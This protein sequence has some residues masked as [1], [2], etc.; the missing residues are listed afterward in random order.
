[1][2][3]SLV[4]RGLKPQPQKPRSL[5]LSK[6]IDRRMF[7]HTGLATAAVSLIEMPSA[8]A[9]DGNTKHWI[10]VASDG[11]KTFDGIH[12]YAH[13]FGDQYNRNDIISQAYTVLHTRFRDINVLRNAYRVGGDGWFVDGDYA[14]Q[15]NLGA[16]PTLNTT[17]DVLWFQMHVLRLPNSAMEEGDEG[18]TPFGEIHAHPFYEESSVR[19]KAPVGIVKV[20]YVKP[21]QYR[22]NG[23]FKVFLNTWWLGG[24]GDGSDP[25]YWASVIAH[26]MLHNL[27]HKHKA[28]EYVDGRQ[29]NAFHRAVYCNGNYRP[30]ADQFPAFG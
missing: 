27:G 20:K 8:R 1:M 5:T 19:G 12:V 28:N 7:L 22:R 15:T 16:H 23:H 10:S 14:R 3:R 4:Q 30:G 17:R 29:M 24:A 25:Y 18:P 2:N 11:A 13:D 26:E 21:G 9:E 6:Q